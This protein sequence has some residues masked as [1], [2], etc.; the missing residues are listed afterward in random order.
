MT[1][2]RI[3]SIYPAPCQCLLMFIGRNNL[4][5]KFFQFLSL[6]FCVVFIKEYNNA[7]VFINAYP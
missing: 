5:G 6:I 4:E 1:R 7:S 3:P 2:I